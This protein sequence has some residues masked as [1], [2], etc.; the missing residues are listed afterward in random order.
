M[1]LQ[2]VYCV[3]QFVFQQRCF[4][5]MIKTTDRRLGERLPL[6]ARQARGV[7]QGPARPLGEQ[8]GT[9]QRPDRGLLEVTRAPLR[10]RE[11]SPPCGGGLRRGAARAV[12]A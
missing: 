10:Q 8:P 11:S 9:G 1:T 12:K 3:F 7:E 5:D 2:F 6:P 4:Y